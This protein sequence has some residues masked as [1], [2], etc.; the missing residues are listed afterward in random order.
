MPRFDGVVSMRVR[1][2]GGKSSKKKGFREHY[3]TIIRLWTYLRLKTLSKSLHKR[4]F[5]TDTT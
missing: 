4:D 2:G 3:G 5:L 1:G